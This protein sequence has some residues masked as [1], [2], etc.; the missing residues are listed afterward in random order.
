MARAR[1]RFALLAAVSIAALTAQPSLAADVPYQQP[2]WAQPNRVA[3]AWQGFYVGVHAGNTWSRFD[4]T[5][6]PGPFPLSAEPSS[7]SG[8]LFAGFNYQVAPQFV[9]GAEADLTLWRLEETRLVG[10]V[11]Y[12]ASSDWQS[13]VRARFGWT[14]DAF[15]IYATGG[16]AFADTELQGPFGSTSRTRVGYALGAGVEGRI[17]D[18]L[19]ARAE[20]IYTNYGSDEYALGPTQRVTG[21]LDTHTLRVGLGFR[22]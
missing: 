7:L 15:M 20:Y 2:G 4:G 22:F 18:N 5:L 8:G 11:G 6:T 13:T 3:A 1:T 12:R 17:T 14:F 16:F 21:D 10:G 9:V 19:F